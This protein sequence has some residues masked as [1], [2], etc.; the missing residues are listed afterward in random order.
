MT[1]IEHIIGYSENLQ[2]FAVKCGDYIGDVRHRLVRQYGID[3]PEKLRKAF[4]NI[5]AEN[6]LLN[7]GIV[8]RVKAGKSSLLNALLFAGQDVLPKAAISEGK[9]LG[10][11]MRS[12]NFSVACYRVKQTLCEELRIRSRAMYF[13]L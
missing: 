4:E 9:C 2:S 13:R 1:N 12:V 3:A 11:M 8:G 10:F 5:M 7:I 6:R